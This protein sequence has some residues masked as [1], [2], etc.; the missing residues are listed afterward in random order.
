MKI[1]NM[2]ILSI[3]AITMITGCQDKAKIDESTI[4]SQE[5]TV[6]NSIEKEVSQ[7]KVETTVQKQPEIINFNLYTSKQEVIEIKADLKNGW[8]FKGFEDKVILLDFFGTWCPP[9]KAEIPHLNNIREKLKK[10]FE[11]IG[12]DI[13]L[14]AGG[15]NSIKTI[16]DF[17]KEFNIKYPITLGG[18]NNKL[19]SA[20]MSL[21]PQ[22]SIP[23]MIL[24]DKK[25]RFVKHYIGMI[26]EEILHSDI[27][28]VIKMK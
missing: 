19:F 25:G 18:D 10:D 7:E 20:V 28:Q 22:G 11:I 2:T 24:F 3:L 13:G 9:C 26:P 6:S 21:N 15:L 23:F 4:V 16:T 27:S 17:K 5:Q 8:K 12:L 14:R 1:K